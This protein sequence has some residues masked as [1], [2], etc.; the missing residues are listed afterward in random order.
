MTFF[1]AFLVLDA[2]R[3]V[4]YRNGSPC[5]GFALSCTKSESARRSAREETTQSKPS[6]KSIGAPGPNPR[7]SKKICGE[8]D[9]DPQ[10]PALSQKLI[11]QYLASVTLHPVGRFVVLAMEC[12]LLAAAIYGCTGVKMD[13]RYM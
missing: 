3:E 13:F 1:V 12:L 6:R 9:Y 5:A 10:K 2:R 7:A 8:G 11:G 4:R